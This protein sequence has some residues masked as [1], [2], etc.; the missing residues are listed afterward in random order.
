MATARKGLRRIVVDD[1][2]YVWRVRRKATDF[3]AIYGDGRLHV[4]VQLARAP[5]S[6]L[7]I[8]TDR[9]HPADWGTR[10]VRAV[11]P[12]DIAAWVRQA[13]RLGWDPAQRGPQVCVN[14]TANAMTRVGRE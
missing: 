4:A 13:L 3:Q 2:V 6:V 14:V 11:T 12:A 5:G 7:V 8:Y 9:P 1:G 10:E